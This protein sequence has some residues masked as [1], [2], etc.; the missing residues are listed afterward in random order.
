MRADGQRGPVGSPDRVPMCVSNPDFRHEIVRRFA[1]A[2]K[3]NPQAPPILQI[4]ENDV[5]AMCECPNCRAWDDPTPTADELAVMPRY[6]RSLYRPYSG[7]ARYARFWQAVYEEARQVD[8]NVIVTAF[9]YSGY[10]AAP[11]ADIKLDPHIVL[12]FCP[13]APHTPLPGPDE[14]M[15]PT[16]YKPMAGDQ[17][18][19]WYPRTPDEQQWVK[20]QWERWQATGA[21][22][23]FRPNFLLNGYAMPHVYTHQLADEFQ[24]YAAHGM[25]GT[26]FDSL[27]GQWSAQGPMLYLLLRLHTRPDVKAENL[28]SEY[29][30]AFGPAA[31]HVRAYFDC[32]ERWTT[33]TL[34]RTESLLVRYGVAQANTYPRLAHEFFPPASFAE[35]ESCLQKAEAAVAKTD[36]PYRDRVAFLRAGFIHANLCARAAAL[37]ADPQSTPEARR[38]AITELAAFRRTVEGQNIANYQPLCYEEKRSWSG[39]PGFLDTP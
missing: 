22:L 2:R 5:H 23:Y 31:P 17:R 34:P 11:K 25:L 27:L 13:Y 26:D 20:A 30:A 21:T 10:A 14:P 16:V 3:K 9:I 7:G 28:L 19:W 35:A 24:Y 36:G 37:F 1:E 12:A 15:T 29:Y 33:N 39:M 4:G 38:A 6:A 18:S 32:W 8:P